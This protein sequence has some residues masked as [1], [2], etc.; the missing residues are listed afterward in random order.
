MAMPAGKLA[1]GL[2]CCA[3]SPYAPL[4]ID[5]LSD[6]PTVAMGKIIL[7]VAEGYLLPSEGERLTGVVKARAKMTELRA[8]DE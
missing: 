1:T 7:A 2:C 3:P 4:D 5:K 8:I 6:D